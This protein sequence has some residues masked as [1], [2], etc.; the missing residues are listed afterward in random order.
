MAAHLFSI[1]TWSSRFWCGISSVQG[2]FDD[3]EPL[4]EIILLPSSKFPE[5][6]ILH[7]LFVCSNATY[8]N[9]LDCL[10]KQEAS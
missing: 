9:E 8:Q 3:R 6:R 10:R 4:D 1:R 5:L 2:L 7:H